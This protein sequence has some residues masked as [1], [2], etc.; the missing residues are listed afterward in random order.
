[1]PA[2]LVIQS[3]REPLPF[4]WLRL[5]LDSVASWAQHNLFEIRFLADEI[6]DLVAPDLVA[7]IG[8]QTVIASDLARLKILQQGLAQGYDRV[9]WCDADFLIF[10]PDK[11][12]LPDADFAL[13][14][15][16]WV[17]PDETGKL[18][19]N[20][21]VHNAFL[22]FCGGNHFLDFYCA[23]AEN[24]LRLNQGRMSPQFIGPKLLTALHNVVQCPVMEVAGML[25]PP[26]MRDLIAGE[27]AALRLFQEKSPAVLAGANLSS[28]LTQCE[29]FSESEMENLVRN[30]CARGI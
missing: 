7:K 15:E 14:R 19:A 28:S 17:Q 5:C 23:T 1:M 13:G 3:H 21:K 22:M 4:D 20:K 27:G 11:F 26:V 25:S 30:L 2:T 24:L 18:R 9:V 6:F 16:V 10:D 12:L 29:G 8:A